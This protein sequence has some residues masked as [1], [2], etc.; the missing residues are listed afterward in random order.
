MSYVSSN[1]YAS[2][3]F[4]E[5]PVALW[6]MDEPSYFVSLIS[7]NEKSINGSNWDLYNLVSSASAFT[8]TGYPFDD[9]D[10]NKFYL[11]TNSPKSMSACLTSTIAYS[12]LDRNKGSLCFSTFIYIPETTLLKDVYIGFLVNG[13]E[14]YKKYSSTNTSVTGV[15]SLL[16][17]NNWEKIT[18]TIDV[19]LDDEFKPFL[20]IE[21]DPEADAG[22]TDTAVYF[23]GTS[24]GEWSEPYNS[25]ST[26]IFPETLPV[27]ISSLIEFPATIECLKL[28][29]YGF[30]DNLDDGYIISVNNSLFAKL[31]GVPM[32][33]GSS[34]NIRLNKDVIKV[35]ELMIDG[36]NASLSYLDI[37]DSGN[38]SSSYSLTID[39]GDSFIYLDSQEY[40]KFPSLVFPGK[41][42]LN[43]YGYNKVLTAEF[44]LRISPETTVKRK[45]FGPLTSED[46]IYVDRDLITVNVGKYSK[47]FFIGKW[48]RPMLV[49]LSQSPEEIFLMIN[50]EKVISISPEFLTIEEFP[51]ENEDFVG[52]YTGEDIYVYEIDSFSIYP[53]IVADQV[54]KKRYVFGQGVQE[55]ENIIA[56]LNGTLSYVDFPFS[57]YS[58]TIRYPDRTSWS[59]AFYN[60]VLTSSEGITLPSYDLPQVIFNNIIANSEYE[61]SLI[62]SNFYKENYNIQDEDYIFM[63]MDPTDSYINDNSTY[64]TIYFSKLNQTN[65]QTKSIHTILK[66]SSNVTDRQ[67]ILYISN[68]FNADVFETF[69]ESGSIQYKFNNTVLKTEN[70]SAE[71][72]FSAGIDLD[73]ISQNYSETVGS[74]FARPDILS[75][76]FAGK[77]EDVFLGKIFSLTI[78]N[79]F[80]T[81]KDGSIIFDSNGFSFKTFNSSLYS[82][83]GAY[84]LT[85]KASN[86]E[87]FF[88]ISATGYWESSI[89]L[90]YFG[91][92]ITQSNGNLK[93]DL[94]LIQF[95][96]D[97]PTSIFSKYNETSSNF[98]NS[99]S[100]KTYITLQQ[101]S[102]LGNFV[103]SDYSEIETIGMDRV[104]DLGL[105]TYDFSNTKFEINDGTVIYP[106]KDVSGFTNYF[107]TVHIEIASKGTIT[108]NIKIKN[109]ALSA[110]SFD[111]GEFYSINTP[112]LGKFYPIVKNQDQYVYKKSIPI[113]I[114]NDSS[115]YLYLSGDSGISVLPQAE[116]DLLKG[117][118]IPINKDLKEDQEIVGIQMFLMYNESNLFTEKRYIGKIFSENEFYDLVLIPEANGKRAFFKIYNQSGEEFLLAKFF[119]NGKLVN[120]IVIEPLTWNYI[121]ISLQENSIKLDGIIAELEIYSGVRVDNIASF[122]ELN[123][124]KQQLVDY[125]EWAL[126]DDAIPPSASATVWQYWSGSSTW[127][128]VLDERSLNVTV[129]SLDGKSIFN[130][131][132]GLS[133]GIGNDDSMISVSEDSIVII[134][135]VTWDTYLV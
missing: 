114:D 64:G 59:D 47:S 12:E 97:A 102:Q 76:N 26:G 100:T 1:L 128:E 8:I 7:E 15:N 42:L 25:I 5:H 134:N 89:P 101:I 57:G 135:D 69:I 107:I 52:F 66:S 113:V 111:E 110:L 61:K 53:Y 130:T 127:T 41:G 35:N 109:M 118:S 72:Y 18:Y 78:N 60:N 122:V 94:D 133:S 99:L 71:S 119:L 93:Y 79:D 3:V 116:G 63:S 65:Y 29:P 106:P 70:I 88:D 117:I 125:D 75:L 55:Q 36:G 85:P 82:Y 124:A 115:P 83:T 129:L 11:D 9:A 73:K 103:Y 48:Y 58:S 17:F 50:G 30:N 120:D 10:V 54:A 20:K 2:R 108:E 112:A 62:Y 91:K 45:I 14:H 68:N 40:H 87:I 4:S 84:T 43:Q 51:A 13:E 6:A 49:H 39:G 32:V 24:V 34:G 96:I 90:S 105:S 86:S 23:N 98:Q 92:Y 77:N 126:L 131:Y 22:E 31:S 16:K 38:A 19:S 33:Y 121:A 95:N 104:L 44:W 56:A 123:P 37:L 21:F 74:F 27:T 80:F 132:A 46:G 81:D 67:S 28:D